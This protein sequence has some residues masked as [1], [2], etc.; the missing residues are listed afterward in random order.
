M[1]IFRYADGYGG[2]YGGGGGGGGGPAGGYGEPY[3]RYD[4]YYKSSGG[5][6]RAYADGGFTFIYI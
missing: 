3:D 4:P 1:N 5:R 6:E 2:G